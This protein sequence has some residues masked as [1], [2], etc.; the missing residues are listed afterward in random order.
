MDKKNI[1]A[2][3]A[4]K[5]GQAN[6]IVI[7]LVMFIV[8]AAVVILWNIFNPFVKEKS[9]EIDVKQFNAGLEIKEAG[10]F[11]T[12]ASRVRVI[13]TSGQEKIEGLKFFFYD[14]KGN[15][16]NEMI[17]DNLPLALESK[18]YFFSPI[19][20]LSKIQKISV[21]PVF[22][23]KLGIGSS[24]ESP[25]ILQ[26]P[27]GLVSWWRFENELSDYL[28]KNNGQSIGEV[29]FIEGKETGNKASSLS[30]DNEEKAAYFDS[31]YINFFNDSSLNLKDEFAISLWLKTN[32]N[33][34][35]ILRKGDNYKIRVDDGQ[36]NFSYSGSGI[37]KSKSSNFKG[38]SDG[39][40]HHLIITNLMLYLDGD[41]D[42]VISINEP[43][44][45]NDE[46]L[47]VGEGFK[48]ALDDIMIFNKSLEMGQVK[49]V[50]E[51][52]D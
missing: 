45:I 51:M 18:V 13:R 52:T 12:G 5:K 29:S 30:A 16:Y 1:L 6:L 26:I 43:F 27:R 7:V 50:F 24:I 23:E 2:E 41:P 40:W 31:G 22:Q 15:S 34:Q 8:I 17:T 3:H 33:N 44:D 9:E 38:F 48:G 20:T 11:V 28:D 47:I 37:I 36:I 19:S 42:K 49:G 10:L 39:K 35:E 46:D 14:E 32:S 4:G 25:S 21:F